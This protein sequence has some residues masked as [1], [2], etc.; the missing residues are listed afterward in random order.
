[1][2]GEARTPASAG[3]LQPGT[4]VQ[5]RYAGLS[6]RQP[7]ALRYR[8]RLQ[9]VDADWIEAGTAREVTYPRLPSGMLRF[10]VQVA[11]APADWTRPVNATGFDLEV[12]TPWWL[13]SWFIL[14]AAAALLAVF[15]LAHYGLA[16]RQHR[17]ARR[18][19][20]E[21]VQRTGQL[22]E[23]NRE[24]EDAS[25]QRELLVEQLAHQASHDSLTGLPNRRAGDQQL[26][27]ALQQADAG[28]APLSV[29]IIDLD[30]FKH[31]NDRYGHQ[32]GDRVLANV[33][34][35]LQAS[36]RRPS[37]F[38][39][40]LGGEEF[41]VVLRDTPLP[42]AVAVLEQARREVAALRVA[43]GDDTSLTCTIS[44]GVVERS[45]QEGAD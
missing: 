30:R 28:H 10:E 14:A 31:I 43:P 37:L 39:G 22:R 6:L 9:G 24:L 23:K 13:R 33:A 35:Q 36:L 8:Y 29:A 45:G 1:V 42:G 16:R 5:I 19:E 11:R 27:A 12:A 21:V 18:L 44:V 26:A 34:L 38:V 2:N 15:A 32:A 4:R 7:N 40:R 17:R 3:V 41:L 20:A 25:R